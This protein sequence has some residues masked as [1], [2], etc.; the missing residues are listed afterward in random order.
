MQLFACHNWDRHILFLTLVVW[1]LLHIRIANDMY[2]FKLHTE[3][4]LLD[5]I[6]EYFSKAATLILDFHYN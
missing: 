6:Y 5:L 1:K 2:N 3:I 4:L